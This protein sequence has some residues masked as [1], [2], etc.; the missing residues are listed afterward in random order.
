MFVAGFEIE[1]KKRKRK[2][3]VLG[4]FHSQ[5]AWKTLDQKTLPYKDLL[6]TT[7]L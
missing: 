7:F 1:K 6:K 4:V 2:V 3:K 5:S